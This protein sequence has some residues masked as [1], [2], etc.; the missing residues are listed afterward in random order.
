MGQLLEQK[1]G[2]TAPR[3]S[4]IGQVIGVAASGAVL[5]VIAGAVQSRRAGGLS[6]MGA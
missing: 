4:A 3:C 5:T 6:G 2:A 1:E